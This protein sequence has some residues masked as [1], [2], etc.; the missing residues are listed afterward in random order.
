MEPAA[1]PQRFGFLLLPRFAMLAFTSAVEPLRAAN[2]LSGRALYAWRF[3]SHDGAP[4]TASN[5]AQLLAQASLA[6]AGPLDCLVVCGGIDAHLFRD[7]A[8]LA[9][10]RRAARAGVRLGAVSDGTFVL[11]RAGLLEG[12]RCT[13]HWQ[14]AEGFREAFPAI[15]LTD[16]LYVIERQR[17]TCSGGTA[18]MDMMLRLIEEAHGRPL[19][20]RVA[21][22]FLH[23]RPRAS[24]DLQRPALRERVGVG[25]PGLVEAVRLMEES[26]ESL[27]P[28]A[29]L[30]R[31]AGLSARQ[32]E[33]LFRQHLG[34]TPQGHYLELRLRRARH[35][36]SHSTLSVTEVAL[37][38]GFASGSHFARRYR[39][40]YAELPRATRLGRGR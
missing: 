24:G 9:W 38:C 27:L 31:R 15:E 10:L 14:C 40:R 8:T 25:H 18:S 32:L 13:I 26:L 28:V 11:A 36:L 12:Q 6:E 5:G 30:A 2:L 29:E 35:L 19:A 17:F 21:E 22:Q 39:A 16:D 7:R 34:T 33:R 20:L 23:E 3:L 37:A 1:A 4:A